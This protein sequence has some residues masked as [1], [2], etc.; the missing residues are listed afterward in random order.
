MKNRKDNGDRCSNFL[1]NP[2]SRGEI[3]SREKGVYLEHSIPTTMNNVLTN[4]DRIN[5]L[6]Q[7]KI[8]LLFVLL[9]V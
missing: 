7:K 4:I 6:I 9:R 2:H 5:N 8:Y 3:Y 1:L